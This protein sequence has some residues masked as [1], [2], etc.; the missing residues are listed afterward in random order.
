MFHL[1]V[2]RLNNRR[3]SIVWKCELIALVPEDEVQEGYVDHAKQVGVACMEPTDFST[4]V[5]TLVTT[6]RAHVGTHRIRLWIY[7]TSCTTAQSL[8]RA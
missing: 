5:G 7:C 6:K 8:S 2:N 3:P 1:S 4:N